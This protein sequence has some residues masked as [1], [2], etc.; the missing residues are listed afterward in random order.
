MRPYGDA[1]TLE[2]RRL[3][4]IR[5]SGDGFGPGEIAAQLGVDRRSVHRW[6]AAYRDHG[7]EALA[8]LPV[9]GRPCKLTAQQR[10]KLACMLL[11]GATALG[12]P[13]DLWTST[14]VADLIRRRLRVSYHAHHVSR[15][16]RSLGF[17]PQKPER[18]ARERDEAAIRRW[19]RTQW[20]RVKK[21]PRG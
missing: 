14:R 21:T 16:L 9:P 1:R 8:P 20:P 11:E 3:R 4:A 7:V 13:T 17:S 10:Q 19:V 6:L 2:Q 15:L 5:L 18:L 12:Y